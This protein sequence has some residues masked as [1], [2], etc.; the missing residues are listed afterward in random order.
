MS[1]ASGPQSPAGY[2]F[3]NPQRMHQPHNPDYL[4]PKYMS[5]G[6]GP[7]NGFGSPGEPSPVSLEYEDGS[8]SPNEAS[9]ERASEASHFTSISERPVNP[10]WQP[11]ASE[12]N[13]PSSIVA[14]RRPQDVI[15]GGNPDFSIPGVGVGRR[16]G[17]SRGATPTAANNIGVGL[18]TGG[19]YPV[20]GEI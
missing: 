5:V 7:T 17:G 9:S 10:N 8:R 19:R 11:S 16:R 3:P 12:R 15:L 2:G 6:G 1:P 14:Q 18:A 20:G 4:H 13:G